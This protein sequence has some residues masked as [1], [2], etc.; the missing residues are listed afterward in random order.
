MAQADHLSAHR[1][2]AAWRERTLWLEVRAARGESDPVARAREAQNRVGAARGPAAAARGQSRVNCSSQGPV[3]LGKTRVHLARARLREARPEERRK[4]APLRGPAVR[5]PTPRA[6]AVLPAAARV[7]PREHLAVRL[8]PTAAGWQGALARRGMRPRAECPL[9]M[10]ASMPVLKTHPPLQRTHRAPPRG[11]A[12]RETW[13]KERTGD[14][15]KLSGM[16]PA[17]PGRFA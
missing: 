8:A 3:K 2:R 6:A 13:A 12:D 7:L 14:S 16:S 10:S 9:P 17:S 5:A 11:A 4:P 15:P 1:L